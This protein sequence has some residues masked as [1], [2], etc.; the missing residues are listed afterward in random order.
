MSVI[1]KFLSESSVINESAAADMVSATFGITNGVAT[2]LIF[3]LQLR[4]KIKRF[5]DQINKCTT[6]KC[7]KRI[8]RKM[9]DLNSESLSTM[10]GSAFGFMGATSRYNA[11]PENI[12]NYLKSGLIGAIFG[13]ITGKVMSKVTLK[14][15]HR[16]Y[17]ELFKELE[18]I[19]KEIDKE[20]EMERIKA[21]K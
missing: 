13:A 20:V 19:E 15:L 10:V 5:K 12:K 14:Q 21:D 16:K 9:K 1:N 4:Y 7:K 18:R 3:Y 17:P 11:R 2:S 6:L 8:I